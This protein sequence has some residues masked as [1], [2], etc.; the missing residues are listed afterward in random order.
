[1]R[2]LHGGGAP[3]VDRPKC[4]ILWLAALHRL[5]SCCIGRICLRSSRPG[6]RA[7]CRTSLVG[8]PPFPAPCLAACGAD[9]CPTSI[10][11]YPSMQLGEH[12]PLVLASNPCTAAHRPPTAAPT[13]A[14]VTNTAN[15]PPSPH[16]S[17]V[18]MRDLTHIDTAR[19]G[20]P[21]N[22]PKEGSCRGQRAGS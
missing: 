16:S 5:L 19:N 3:M 14:C 20:R 9:R 12:P 15:Q 13:Q 18:C 4:S 1:V 7:G 17:A 21:E 22:G 6:K 11:I 10:C 8:F 2:A